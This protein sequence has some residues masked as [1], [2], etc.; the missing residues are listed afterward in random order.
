MNKGLHFTGT[1]KGFYVFIVTY[2]ITIT[3]F[4]SNCSQII[5]QSSKVIQ[6]EIQVTGV[7]FFAD[8]TSQK[9]PSFQVSS[10]DLLGFLGVLVRKR[11]CGLTSCQQGTPHPKGPVGQDGMVGEAQQS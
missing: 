3:K 11:K 9:D 1:N 5:D 6:V 10:S 4:L 8:M 2:F 7:G